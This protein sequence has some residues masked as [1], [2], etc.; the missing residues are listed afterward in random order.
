M[1][2]NLAQFPVGKLDSR[3]AQ[4]TTVSGSPQQSRLFFVT[5]RHTGIRFLVDTGAQVSV[6]RPR[7]ADLHRLSTVELVAAGL[8][9]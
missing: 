8:T 3:P 5:D 9:L 1:T 6:I 2:S 4:A 7:P